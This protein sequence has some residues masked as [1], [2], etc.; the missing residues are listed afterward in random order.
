MQRENKPKKVKCKLDE[1]QSDF[2]MF[3]KSPINFAKFIFKHK[4]LTPCAY[5]K[6]MKDAAEKTEKGVTLKIALNT[7]QFG[8]RRK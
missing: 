4:G 7:N 6:K 5:I 2:E 8:K 1:C 3:M